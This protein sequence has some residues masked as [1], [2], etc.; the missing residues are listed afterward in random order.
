M[1]L[2]VV[3][4]VLQVAVALRQVD[5]QEV[6]QEVLQLRAEVRGEADLERQRSK[7]RGQV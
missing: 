4:P 7:V 5:L 1:S 6:A 3:H 2:D